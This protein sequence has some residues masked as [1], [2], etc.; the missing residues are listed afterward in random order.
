MFKVCDSLLGKDKDPPLPPGFMNQQ[1]ADNFNDFFITKITNIRSK[2]IE[3]NLG[4]PE[5]LTE[6]HT[7][8]R[9]RENYQL[10][11]CDD[12]AKIVLASPTKTCEAD[13]I[14]TELL[15]KVLPSIIQLLTK[16][17]NESLQTGE[18]PDD[19]K[20]ALVKALLKKITLEPIN[21]NYR[22]VSNLP[23]MGKLMERCVIDELMDHI[24]TNNL[25][26]PLQ[27]AYR[28][29]HSSDTALL[30]V[31][32]D[33][34][35]ATD[36]QE[37]T[38][39]VLLDLSAAF[40]M[41]HHKILLNWLENHFGIKGMTLRWIE[42]YLTNWSQRVV[43]GDMKTAGAKTESMSLKFGVPQGSV[44]GPILFTLYTYPFGQI[45]TKHVLYH[46]Y[47][48]DQQIYLIFKPGPTGVQSAQDDCILQIERCIEEIRNWMAMN[49]LKLNDDKTEFIIF[50]LI[51][52]LRKLTISP[53]G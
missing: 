44:L 30:K 34:L 38:C 41:A 32:A 18:F 6:H 39:L 27:S 7:I 2:L 43:I 12:V 29:C 13:P 47:A 15:K 1:L 19:L 53:L 17:V 45:C 11:S 23:F 49:M 46:L 20:E 3:Q 10:I 36:N 28:L 37:I 48:D 42:S 26:E 51:N 50:E 25:M 22:P 8:P 33:I 9:V 5:I 24:H 14:P 4:S 21:K 40:N 35:K 52:N 31:K 16:L